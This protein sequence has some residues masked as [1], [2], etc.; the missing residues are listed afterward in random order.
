ME[1]ALAAVYS[2]VLGVDRVGVDDDFFAD[3]GDSIR[4]IQVVSR[5]RA[6]GVRLRAAA[7]MRPRRVCGVAPGVVPCVGGISAKCILNA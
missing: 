4:S 6:H 3:G 7:Q 1:E 5:A 2:E